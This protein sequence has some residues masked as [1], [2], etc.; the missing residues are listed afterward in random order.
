MQ[1]LQSCF[2]LRDRVAL[3]TGGGGG[4]GL[5]ICESLASAGANVVSVGTRERPDKQAANVAYSVLDITD[6]V[7]TNKFIDQNFP[8]GLDILVNNAAVM[9]RRQATTATMQPTF[10]VNFFAAARLCQLVFPKLIESQ[11]GGRVV[12]IASLSASRGFSSGTLAYS[13]SKAAMLSMTRS[14]C[15]E[16]AKYDINVNSISPGWFPS[17]MADSGNPLKDAA[18]TKKILERI[19]TNVMGDPEKLAAVVL[20]LCGPASSYMSGQNVCVDAGASIFG[21]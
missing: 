15:V 5:A 21:F 4:L 20:F 7:A 8:D 10:D 1:Y 6:A 17:R 9:C 2:G 13:A 16:W 14:P 18:R 11:S 12:N 3:V 19:P